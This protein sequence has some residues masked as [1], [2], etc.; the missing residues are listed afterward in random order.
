MREAMELYLEG[1]NYDE[2]KIPD[3]KSFESFETISFKLKTKAHA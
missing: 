2:E 1:L 3:D